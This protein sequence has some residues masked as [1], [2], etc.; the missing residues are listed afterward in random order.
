MSHDGP[1]GGGSAR[2][3]P[4]DGGSAEGG[5]RLGAGGAAAR[6]G[7]E[8]VVLGRG[9]LRREPLG[10]AGAHPSMGRNEVFEAFD[11]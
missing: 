3:G 1:D 4:V 5:G 2:G 9:R 10:R 7:E 11:S 6:R 8:A